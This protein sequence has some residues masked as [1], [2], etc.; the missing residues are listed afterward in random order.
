MYPKID[1]FKLVTEI[2]KIEHISGSEDDG[3]GQQS[4]WPLRVADSN[5]NVIWPNTCWDGF[6]ALVSFYL[7]L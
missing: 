7:E 2:A 3:F 6:Q 1:Q 4:S 5:E